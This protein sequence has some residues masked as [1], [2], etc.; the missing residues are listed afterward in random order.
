MTAT[1]PLLPGTRQRKR[2]LLRSRGGVLSTLVDAGP[3]AA[4]IAVF[5]SYG[6]LDGSIAAAAGTNRQNINNIRR[7]TYRTVT[8]EL[9]DRLL[10]LT[11]VDLLRHVDDFHQVTP[12]GAARRV[13]A[14]AVLGWPLTQQIPGRVKLPDQVLRADQENR[15]ITA[16][17][18]RR[19]AAVYDT[20][21][22]T[23]G[24][25]ARARA[26]ARRRRWPAP[27]DWDDIDNPESQ[28]VVTPSG[29]LTDVEAW[30][31]EVRQWRVSGVSADSVLAWSGVSPM[32]AAQRL[33]RHAPDLVTPFLTLDMA[34]RRHSR[35]AGP[36]QEV[37][38]DA[39]MVGVPSRRTLRR[40]RPQEAGA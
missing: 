35:T 26:Y 39:R 32:V 7:G 17:T 37:N 24:P 3:A 1:Q 20:L 8:R 2:W 38:V 9:S 18:H 25:S 11:F 6:Y 28:P 5:R 30:V 4:A 16:R 15:T 19:T 29:G 34:S 22:M 27:L 21:S 14:L 13:R 33:R 31:A 40:S 23:P 10:S 36:D 12:V